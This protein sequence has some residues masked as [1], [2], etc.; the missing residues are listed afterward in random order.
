[1]N[2]NKMIIV[3]YGELSTKGKNIMDFIRLLGKNIKE[4]SS[5]PMGIS[6]IKNSCNYIIQ[7][8]FRKRFLRF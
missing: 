1:M 3:F 4:I 8:C 2:S 5:K 7:G 6:Q